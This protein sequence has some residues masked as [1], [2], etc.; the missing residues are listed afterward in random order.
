MLE[1]KRERVSEIDAE[2][3]KLLGERTGIAREVGKLKEEK[4][5]AV[6][7]TGRE[8]LVIR[9]VGDLA[10]AVDLPVEDVR[11]IFWKIVYMCRNAQIS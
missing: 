6:L 2:I 7:D 4:Q 3:V 5:I 1:Q 10:R 8:A 11:D 9:R